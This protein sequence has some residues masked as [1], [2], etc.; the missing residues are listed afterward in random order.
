MASPMQMQAQ[1]L[2]AKESPNIAKAKHMLF[3]HQN[4]ERAQEETTR[5]GFDFM[6]TRNQFVSTQRNIFQKTSN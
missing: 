1:D 3:V 4:M 2:A 6:H 5:E